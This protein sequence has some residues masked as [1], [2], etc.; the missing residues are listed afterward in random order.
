MM[1][2]AC[3][4]EAVSAVNMAI[5]SERSVSPCMM[6]AMGMSVQKYMRVP[7]IIFFTIST[8]SPH[9]SNASGGSR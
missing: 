9:K 7:S 4:P 3:M 1:G 2:H 6:V 8:K 5:P